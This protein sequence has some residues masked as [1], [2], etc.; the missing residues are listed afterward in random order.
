MGPVS[1]DWQRIP[2]ASARD[3]LHLGLRSGP[4]KDPVA[5]NVGNPHAVFFVDDIAAIDMR[6]HAP[7]IQN[8]A[9][10]PQQTNVGAAQLI[11]STHLRVS[12]YERG[13]G[14]TAACGSGAC[15]AVFAA[16]A[17]GLTGSRQMTV[18]MRAGS[19]DIEILADDT[20]V[21]TGP[22]AFCFSGCLPA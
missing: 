9:L 8:D 7:K 1:M 12:V 13:A 2:L 21:M 18:E 15:A 16:N 6:S 3:T 17:R 10:F 11:D 4:L 20:A 19:V 14:L 22:V 5:V